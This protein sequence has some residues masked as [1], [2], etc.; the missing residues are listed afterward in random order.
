MAQLFVNNIKFMII[1]PMEHKSEASNALL[2]LIL[3]IG[4]LASLHCDGAMELQY[5][6]LKNIC[7]DYGI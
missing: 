2:E 4:I 6:K 7:Q 5:G 3:D 1:M